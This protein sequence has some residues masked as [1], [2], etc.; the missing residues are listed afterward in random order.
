MCFHQNVTFLSSYLHTYN[1]EKKLNC[2]KAKLKTVFEMLLTIWHTID[3]IITKGQ[4]VLSYCSKHQ[5][6]YQKAFHNSLLFVP[7]S[8]IDPRKK[9]KRLD[10]K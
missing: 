4:D 7:F 5:T 3:T 6:D 2:N 8:L 1:G 10:F 9:K